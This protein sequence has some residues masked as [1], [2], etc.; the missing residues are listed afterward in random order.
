MDSSEENQFDKVDDT[1]QKL[2]A[3][4]EHFEEDAS[5]KD[6]NLES[7]RLKTFTDCPIKDTERGILAM[8]GFFY[9]K[10]I[11]QCFF[12]GIRFDLFEWFDDLLF[13]HIRYSPFCNF[14][15]GRENNNVAIDNARLQQ[16]LARV[17][18]Y[19]FIARITVPRG[20]FE[21]LDPEQAHR[22]YHRMNELQTCPTCFV[23]H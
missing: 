12:C 6:L 18:K 8:H 22:L 9:Y 16:E 19:Y 21:S 20:K 23:K 2:V 13:E 17:P 1:L 3:S 5:T 10:N 11:V 14:V 15:V 4:Q 7:E